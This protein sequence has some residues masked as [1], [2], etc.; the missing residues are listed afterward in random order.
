MNDAVLEA[1][2]N[3]QALK[4]ES[5]VSKKFKEKADKVIAILQ[6]NKELNVEKAIMELEEISNSDASTY[7]RTQIWAVISILESISKN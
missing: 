3:L 7:L 2:E 6:S 4:E 1:I 5:D